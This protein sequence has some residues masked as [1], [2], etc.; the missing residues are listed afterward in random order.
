MANYYINDS[1]LTTQLKG[2]QVV[3]YGVSIRAFNQALRAPVPRGTADNN[4]FWMGY[5]G[6]SSVGWVGNNRLSGLESIRI[7]DITPTLHAK[8]TV[9]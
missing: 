9:K 2:K 5:S 1:S 8:P 6:G 7:A 3:I 4:R